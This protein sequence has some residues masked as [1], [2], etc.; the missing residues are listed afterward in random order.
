M[1]RKTHLNLV[2]YLYLA[3]SGVTKKT[4]AIQNMKAI[5]DSF[6]LFAQRKGFKTQAYHRF[7][8]IEHARKAGSIIILSLPY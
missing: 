7:R 8:G 5:Q 3:V 4:I 6:H 1:A 2:S